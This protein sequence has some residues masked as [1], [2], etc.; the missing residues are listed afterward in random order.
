MKKLI[1]LLT[2]IQISCA[3]NL[4]SKQR[5]IRDMAIGAAVGSLI[6]QSKAENRGPYTL[7]YAGLGATAG[8]VVNIASNNTDEAALIK[9]NERLKAKLEEFQ[10]SIEP[11]LVSQGS[12]LFS[13]PLPKEVASLVEPGEWKRYR[14]DQW[15]QDP[16]N[17]NQWYRQVEL[18][19]IVP[20]VPR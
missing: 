12:S 15:V 20:P 17:P 9:E 16:S 13:S 3:S 2:A 18:F 19:E 4:S 7:M 8:A 10:K 5:I 6:G 1:L 14:M 11:K